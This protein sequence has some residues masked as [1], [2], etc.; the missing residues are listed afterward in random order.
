MNREEEVRDI[1]RRLKMID[2]VTLM[3]PD[4]PALQYGQGAEM[5]R[6]VGDLARSYR[7]LL[8]LFSVQTGEVSTWP[9]HQRIRRL[10]FLV[11][12]KDEGAH[13][14]LIMAADTLRDYEAMLE[15]NISDDRLG[16]RSAAL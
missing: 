4:E 9:L 1:Q 5:M 15:G 10:A 7:N 16:A 6:E 12:T 14:D 11:D 2:L 13:Q 8:Q 3:A